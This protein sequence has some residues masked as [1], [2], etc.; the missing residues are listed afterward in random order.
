MKK[1]RLLALT[2]ALVLALGLCPAAFAA[3]ADLAPTQVPSQDPGAIA[4]ES[5]PLSF[6]DC[7]YSLKDRI[8]VGSKNMKPVRALKD[9]NNKVLKEGKG[10]RVE[11]FRADPYGDLTKRMKS[12]PI[13]PGRYIAMLY[14]TDT[15]KYSGMLGL[16]YQ[17]VGKD[18]VEH[19]FT[20]KQKAAVT[21]SV[22]EGDYR[23]LYDSQT[24]WTHYVKAGTKQHAVWVAAGLIDNLAYFGDSSVWFFLQDPN[25]GAYIIS[26]N[27]QSLKYGYTQVGLTYNMPLCVAVAEASYTLNT[28]AD[29]VSNKSGRDVS[30]KKTWA[31]PQSYNTLKS[32]IANAEK[33]G[34][35]KGASK[36]K[37][38]SATAK[39]NKALKGF[40]PKPG[41]KGQKRNLKKAKVENL[42]SNTYSGGSIAQYP[43]VTWGKERLVPGKHYTVSYKYGKKTVKARGMKAVGTYKAIITGKGTCTGKV[44]KSFKILKT[45]LNRWPVSMR[46]ISTQKLKKEGV[47]VKPKVTVMF[48]HSGY[49]KTVNLKQGR[50]YTVTYRNNTKRGQAKA[51]LTGKGNYTGTCTI[52]FTIE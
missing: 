47:A 51:I 31:S 11:Y 4:T 7:R 42:Q 46:G 43:T 23:M 34:T 8:P 17:V 16:Y 14:P 29:T 28:L 22:S 39:L 50:D 32:A 27:E 1:R 25:K 2:I 26:N 36:A 10:Y 13:K 38:K 6:A 18:F 41:K 24:P 44:T 12:A 15:G 21:P 49:Q 40:K 37:V 20:D 30:A 45:P 33:I 48:Y 19:P 9:A 35:K 3:G 52:Q 5:A